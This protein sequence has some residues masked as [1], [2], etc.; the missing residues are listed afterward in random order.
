MRLDLQ[1]TLSELRVSLIQLTPSVAKIIDIGHLPACRRSSRVAKPFESNLVDAVT[2]HVPLYN[3]NGPTEATVDYSTRL[4]E[5]KK[6][7]EGPLDLP[8][9]SVGKP[10][11]LSRYFVVDSD[12]RPC[13]IGQIGEV[14]VSGPQVARGYLNMPEQTSKSFVQAPHLTRALQPVSSDGD[15]EQVVDADSAYFTGDMGV[16]HANGELQLIGRRDGQVKI[17]GLRIELEEIAAVIERCSYVSAAAALVGSDGRIVSFVAMA[18][19]NQ[20]QGACCA[21]AGCLD[22]TGSGGSTFELADLHG[23]LANRCAR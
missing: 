2:R 11:G 23:P 6:A 7:Q 9:V 8:W 12:Q 17:N 14:V 13:A 10:I 16:L 20:A 18:K 21:R 4:Y 15:A 19:P 3:S 5:K 22:W 1:H